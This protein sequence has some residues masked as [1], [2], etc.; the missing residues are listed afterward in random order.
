M[1]TT[2]YKLK[3]DQYRKARGGTSKFL[4]LY[5][6]DCPQPLLLYQKDG[7][8]ILKRLYVDRILAVDQGIDPHSALLICPQCHKHIGT[9]YIYEKE[10]RPAFLLK[11]GT[12]RKKVTNP[13]FP[14][15]VLSSKHN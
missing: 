13:I 2:L 11:R 6:K 4:T 12:L 3:N 7:G 10:N 5:Y 15:K 8:G 9:A 14:G 1:S